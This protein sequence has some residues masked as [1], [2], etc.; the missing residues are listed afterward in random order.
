MKIFKNVRAY[1][2]SKD[3]PTLK[4]VQNAVAEKV[5]EDRSGSMATEW[6]GFVPVLESTEELAL[7]LEGWIFIKFQTESRILPSGAVNDAVQKRVSQIEDAE[8]RKV[9]AKEKSQIKDDILQGMIP[10]AFTRKKQTQ[11]VIDRE[12][13]VVYVDARSP[14]DAEHVLS[15]LREKLGTLPVRPVQSKLPMNIS[16][17]QWIK[18]GE[19]T[20]PLILGM[21]CKLAGQDSERIQITNSPT[22]AEEVQ[23][24][25]ATGLLPQS[26]ELSVYDDGTEIASF[27]LNEDLS[28]QRFHLDHALL[29]NAG[30]FETAHDKALSDATLMMNA[31]NQSYA[32]I[33]TSIGGEQLPEAV[34][35]A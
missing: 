11:A 14:G 17:A 31:L 12:A 26:I 4:A 3:L 34:D 35:G 16:A 6:S 9:Y 32:A 30:E 23:A 24:H 10:R 28:L 1:R 20:M 13:G 18:D 33:M 7:S 21:R 25:L 19:A 15:A 2:A 27:T 5:F 29:D 8:K 22:W